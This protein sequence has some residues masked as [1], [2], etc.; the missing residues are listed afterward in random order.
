MR[1]LTTDVAIIGA[2]T[3]G[4][5]A[6]REVE[7]AGRSWLLIESGPYG[8]TCARTGCMPSKLLIA[9]A[10]AARG[11]RR[12]RLFGVHIAPEAIR[13]D[14]EAVLDRVRRERDR[15][16]DLNAQKV[17]ALP[18]AQRL[19]GR[20]RFVG[21][22]E[23]MVGD[24]TL[25][26]AQAVVIASGSTPLIPR[27]LEG[28]MPQVLTSDSL[29][30]LPSLPDSIAVFGTGA[31]GLE[32]GQAL[33]HL[34]VR[35]AFYNPL[36]V[37]GPFTDPVVAERFREVLDADLQLALG[38]KI[39]ETRFDAGCVVLHHR[40]PNGRQHERRFS[41]VLAAIGRK[42]NLSDLCLEHSGLELDDQGTPIF[43]SATMQCGSAPVFVAGDIDGERPVL[44]EAEHEG[45]IAGANAARYPN[46]SARQRRVALSIG[47]TH[48]QLAMLGLT[49]KQAAERDVVIGESSYDDQGRARVIGQNRGLVRLY[50]DRASHV[51][52]GAELFGPGVEHTAHLLAWAAQQEL[53]I[54][55][56]LRMPFYHPTLEE[57]IR[58]AL[59]D[60]GH[61]LDLMNGCAPEDRGDRVG[62]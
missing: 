32:L 39:L 54:A 19:S 51:L 56:L 21:K 7:R 34:G 3:A 6:R 61:K 49:H 33:H 22:T 18:V 29:F 17:L 44:H 55:D 23:L 27:E 4:L 62:D 14:R 50:V 60:A 45:C 57:G 15:F 9:A 16:S 48:P 13:I 20:A 12:A 2:G 58:T 38:A 25:V 42:P 59:R 53:A 5:N 52:L 41:K 1:T 11:A 47:F 37:V 28:I 30:E 46:V 36:E 43:D 8:T 31:I 35:V 24:H 10:D 26:Q 40:D